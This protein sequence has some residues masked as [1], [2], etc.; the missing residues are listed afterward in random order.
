MK[1]YK[2]KERK[3]TQCPGLERKL[4][5]TF[6]HVGREE[7]VRKEMLSLELAQ[8]TWLLLGVEGKR[9]GEKHSGFSGEVGG[10][11]LEGQL[12][13]EPN[14]GQLVCECQGREKNK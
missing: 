5:H 9:M 12:G 3:N 7:Q 14:P 8:A 13:V 11:A 10:G 1:F 6:A 2:I 4:C